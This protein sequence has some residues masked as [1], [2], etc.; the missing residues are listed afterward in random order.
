MP[1]IIQKAVRKRVYLKLVVTGPSGSGKT[2]GSIGLAMG[3]APNKKVLVIDTENESAGYYAGRFDFDVIVMHAPFTTAKYMEC[4][5]A[6]VAGGYEVLVID[7]LTH[8]WAGSG[9]LQD[10]KT[11]KD[12]RGGNSYTNWGEMKQA[13]NKFTEALLQS[14]IHVVGTLRSKM[15]YVLEENDRGKQT[16]RKVGLAPISA[17]DMEYEFGVVFDVERESHLAIASKDRM[18]LFEGR[19]FYL[20]EAIGKEIAAWLDGGAVL[21]P[22][23]SPASSVPALGLMPAS[24]VPVL[25]K[26]MDAAGVPPALPDPF[27]SAMA[28]LAIVTVGMPD[29][30][31]NALVQSFEKEG[32]TALPALLEEIKTIKA[33]LADPALKEPAVAA[34]APARPPEP[35]ESDVT[36][37]FDAAQ[38]EALARKPEVSKA[39]SDFV[40][41]IDPDT[42]EKSGGISP[43][44]YEAL[45]LLIEANGIN[46]DALRAYC[47]KAGHLLPSAHPTLARM[48]RE[49][50]GKLRTRLGSK[51]AARVV[52]II[53]KTPVTTY[54]APA[55]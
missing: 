36:A 43:I 25:E 42:D 17:E 10:Q 11:A 40:D 50:F 2:L 8:E 33:A 26:A 29:K 16:P 7:S 51:D 14:P 3:L 4:L 45:G 48:K 9:G 52:G 47:V 18:G 1:P 6:A 54:A 22:I 27:V 31:R 55:A 37:A 49:E 12:A 44:E 19:Q 53:N 39:A 38:A 35:T 24:M 5:N 41:S 15:A 28:E 21:P 13:H 23:A 32:P 20:D 34:P 30:T 46:R